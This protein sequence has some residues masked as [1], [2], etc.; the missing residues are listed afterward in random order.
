MLSAPQSWLYGPV[1][2]LSLLPCVFLIGARTRAVRNEPPEYSG[3]RATCSTVAFAAAAV[4]TILNI[5]FLLSYLRNGGGIHGSEPSPGVWRI[6]GPFSAYL[7]VG[8]MVLA[9]IGKA[10]GKLFFA[11]WL[12]LL[13]GVNYVVLLAAFD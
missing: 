7:A 5:V 1:I 11:V 3:W 2:F 9:A 13:F 12:I 10:K 4:A 8:S 6:L